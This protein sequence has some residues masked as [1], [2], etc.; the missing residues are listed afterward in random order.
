LGADHRPEASAQATGGLREVREVTGLQRHRKAKAEMTT[1]D[2]KPMSEEELA[3]IARHTA[4]DPWPSVDR[5]VDEIRR[6]NRE[7]EETHATLFSVCA[8]SGMSKEDLL[9]A[10]RYGHRE[11][12]DQIW[13]EERKAFAKIAKEFEPPDEDSSIQDGIAAAILARAKPS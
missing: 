5:M 12:A 2:A 4:H 11:A 7:L 10:I 9:N 6:L 3:D 8:S 13:A 1:L